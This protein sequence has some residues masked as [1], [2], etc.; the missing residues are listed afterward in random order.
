VLKVGMV[1]ANSNNLKL[2]VPLDNTAMTLRDAI[3]K[4]V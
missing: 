3:T 1:H 4:K 2:E